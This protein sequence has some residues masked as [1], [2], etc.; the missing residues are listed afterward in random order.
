MGDEVIKI[1]ELL[2]NVVDGLPENVVEALYVFLYGEGVEPSPETEE[3]IKELK[4][5]WKGKFR[6][7][8]KGNE[9]I[10]EIL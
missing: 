10:I 6:V 9:V 4:E 5:K 2:G 8:R 7:E 1:R 3:L